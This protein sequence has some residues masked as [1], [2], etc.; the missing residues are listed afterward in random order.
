M[1][2]AIGCDH[3]A[4]EEK[5]KIKQLLE[6]LNHEVVDCGT[7]S[8]KSVD[9]PLYGHAVAFEVSRNKVDRGIV[10]CGSGIGVSIAANKVKN[11]RAA[12]CTSVLHAQLSRQH[13]D[14]NVLAL[15]ARVTKIEDLIEITQTWLNTSFEGGRHLNRINMIEINEQ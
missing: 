11:I 2:I 5:N 1:K 3:A 15:G 9:Y 14:S 7:D 10:I 8:S 12:L 13:N 6:N 4:Y